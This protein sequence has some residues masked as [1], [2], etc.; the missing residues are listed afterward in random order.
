MEQA[1]LWA[2][3][4]ITVIKGLIV[5][6]GL[7]VASAYLTTWLER[8]LIARFQLRLGPNRV[9]PFGLLQPLADGL[10]L[11]LK[12]NFM[13]QEA[14]RFI[15]LLAPAL[16]M[17]A[18]FV[19]FAVIPY[20]PTHVQLLGVRLFQIADP[21]VGILFVLAVSS[22]GIYGII[23]GGWAGGSKYSLLGGLRS[24]AQMISY[25]LAVGLTIV[26]VILLA[27]TLK[28]SVIVEQQTSGTIWGFLPR[29]NIFLQPLGFLLL[30]IGGTAE[31]NRA[32]FDLPEAEHELVG[33]FHTEYGGM[34]F[35]SFFI[36][37]YANMVIAASVI[38]TLFLGGW[39]GPFV[40]QVPLLGVVWF[41]LKVFAF[42]F[43]FI[44]MRA[45]IPRVRYDQLMS[46]GWKLLIPLALLNLT[47]TAVIVMIWPGL[48]RG[49]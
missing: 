10:K 12:E 5:L 15:F 20:G 24:S 44:W 29:W 25:E 35:A 3:V 33:G 9:G 40:E 38:T 21:N 30:L 18:A 11:A 43:L 36:A 32:P 22:I 42:M 48:G 27:G 2:V 26:G 16:S 34:R 28:L 39:D 46:I 45:T 49:V 14:D 13:P 8:R 37:E 23:L 31:T 17:L 6:V 47:V 19:A 1:P 41:A 4:L 7:L